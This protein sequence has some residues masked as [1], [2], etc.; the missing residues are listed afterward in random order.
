MTDLR[1]E[2]ITLSQLRALS[3]QEHHATLAGVE[4][5]IG[6]GP[7]LMSLVSIAPNLR[8]ISL[9]SSGFESLDL[10]LATARGL[11]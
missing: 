1:F 2:I 8:V 10:D 5:I 6:P 4:V 3:A 7:H 9:A 11:P